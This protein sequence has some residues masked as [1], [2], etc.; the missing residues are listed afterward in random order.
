MRRWWSVAIVAFA[1]AWHV[2]VVASPAWTSVAPDQ[3][4]RDFASYYYAVRVAGDGG[5]PWKRGALGAEAR[6]DATRRGVHPFL[7]PPPFLATVW[8][9]SAM[10]LGPAFHAWFWLDEIFAL[11]A[12][13]ALWRAWRGLGPWIGALV[14]LVGALMTAV[15]NNHAMGQANF[16]PLA[17]VCAAWWAEEEDEPLFAGALVGIAC[18]LKMSP[19]LY[20]VVWLAQRKW[21]QVG[22]AVG[23]AVLV[24]LLTL[25]LVGPAHQLRFFV[26]VLP[27]FSS[28]GYNG[29]G[30]PINLFGNHSFPNLVDRVFP[31]DRFGLAPT[32]RWISTAF[33]LVSVTAL[34]WGFRHPTPDPLARA[35]RAGAVGVLL[36]L[37]PVY[38]YEHHLVWAFPAAIAA[39]V[40]ILSGRLPEW[41]AALV[42]AAVAIL[43]FDLD[44]LREITTLHKHTLLASFTAEA[45]TGALVVLL[46]VNAWLGGRRLGSRP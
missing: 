9:T 7:Y 33:A 11:A 25:P 29:L 36:L 28:G 15:P 14:A 22:A 37:V 46:G 18:M 21:R 8:W 17:L 39:I 13:L 44:I 23:V 27:T 38:T 35:A 43:A 12:A 4:G 16:L 32:A 20:V 34:A 1:L 24:S 6:E 42:G 45:K 10:Q 41:V 3:S 2:A 40:A 26:E 5:D 31:G 30:V 19:A